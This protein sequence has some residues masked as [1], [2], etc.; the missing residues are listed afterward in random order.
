MIKTHRIIEF[1]Q[2]FMPDMLAI[3]LTRKTACLW[4]GARSSPA[5][6]LVLGR[7]PQQAQQITV[8]AYNQ[9][10]GGLLDQWSR[11]QWCNHILG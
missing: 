3:A 2:V 8:T 11:Q 9:L 4:A 5:E 6:H 10:G 1:R 7:Y